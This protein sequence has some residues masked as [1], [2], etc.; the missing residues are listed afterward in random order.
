V[1]D[2]THELTNDSL[3][4]PDKKAPTMK[5]RINIMLLVMLTGCGP[6]TGQDR[7]NP[8]SDGEVSSS[9]KLTT[10]DVRRA[11]GDG[12]TP[13][14]GA[15]QE[16]LGRLVFDVGQAVQWPTYINRN[17]NFIF[18]SLFGEKVFD[19][20][21]EIGVQNMRI[22]VVGPT[23]PATLKRA[24]SDAP[25][26]KIE[27]HKE[28]INESAA[29]AKRLRGEKNIS[30]Q[31]QK[32][33][34]DTEK[35][36]RDW[37]NVIKETE[38][39]YDKFVLPFPDNRAFWKGEDSN[40]DGIL[41]HSLYRAYLFRSEFTYIFE[42]EVELT[43]GMTK[44]RHKQQFLDIVGRFRPRKSGEIPTDLGVCFPY[45]FIADDGKMITDIKQSL[46]W[47]DAPGVIYSIQTGNVTERN[48][49][50][51]TIRAIGTAAAARVALKGEG[52]ERAVLTLQVGPVL[53]RI[54]GLRAS[55]GGFALRISNPGREPFEVYNVFTG[56]SGWG[57]SAVL[58]FILIEM[59]TRTMEQ[60][61]E[62]K[63][64]P[65]PFKQSMDRL[66]TLLKSTRLRPTTPLMPDVA[67][68]TEKK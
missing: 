61:P 12:Y 3:P 5:L 66:D 62:L 60:A 6:S 55:Q 67:A 31:S 17:A 2:S 56:Y 35:D 14:A 58:P 52:G 37:E 36:I 65:P 28:Y 43:E 9:E 64:N 18:S 33:I 44:E 49:K 54:G 39:K 1:N 24:Y 11:M 22:A 46:R 48:T 50:S 42:S 32:E 20:G 15:Q 19:R 4:G 26:A 59:S 41:T 34:A 13:L 25:W 45:G 16:C 21:D 10:E 7:S 23:T 53:T 38:L 47:E 57:G 63:T 29:Y 68:L 51:A 40:G 30:K 8:S 27:R